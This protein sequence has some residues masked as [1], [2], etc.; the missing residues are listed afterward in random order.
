MGRSRGQKSR[1]RNKSS[2]PQVPQN[3]KADG[4]DTEFNREL[5]DSDDLQAAARSKAADK[6]AKKQN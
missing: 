1:D 4:I 5:A 2:L 3:M 6:R